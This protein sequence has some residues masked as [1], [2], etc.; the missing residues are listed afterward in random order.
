MQ[1]TYSRLL[2]RLEVINSVMKLSKTQWKTFMTDYK[3]W[4]ANNTL[5]Y[6]QDN[7]YF[8]MNPLAL[9]I[10]TKGI[11]RQ[12]QARSYFLSLVE[13]ED[14]WDSKNSFENEVQRM[15]QQHNLQVSNMD[16]LIEKVVSAI[17]EY[18]TRERPKTILDN[19]WRAFA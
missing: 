3:K 1:H 4:M 17:K 19:T 2:V 16:E 18:I 7:N 10:Y 15:I 11:F 12:Q 9:V 5:E 8:S 13:R 6:G 14:I